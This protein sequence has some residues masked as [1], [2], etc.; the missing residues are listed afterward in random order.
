MRWRPL[1]SRS[2]AERAEE[3]DAL[4][5]GVPSWLAPGLMRWLIDVVRDMPYATP[6]P[7]LHEVEQ[8]LRFRLDWKQGEVTAL[9]TLAKELSENRERALDIVD[10]LLML[11]AQRPGSWQISERL[12][13]MLSAAGSAWTVGKDPNGTPCLQRRVEEF[14]ET[15]AKATIA[16]PGNAGKHLQA[17]WH[18]VYGRDPDSSAAYREAV[19]AVEAAAKPVV[20]PNDSIATLGKMIR[21]IRDKP[22]K[23]TTELGSVSTVAEMMGELWTSQLDRH[24]TDDETVPLSVSASQAEAAVHLAVTLVHWFQSGFVRTA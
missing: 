19:R 18:R 21:A 1:S 5:D 16:R 20:T 11:T 24:G 3:Y 22:T 13:S 17:A 12:S 9:A 14:A 23:W 6:I 8:L 10:C 4:H 15:A 7:T 2:E